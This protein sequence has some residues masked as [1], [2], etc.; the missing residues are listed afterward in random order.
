MA[1]QAPGII[2]VLRWLSVAIIIAAAFRLFMYTPYYAKSA[3]WILDHLVSFEVNPVAAQSQKSGQLSLEDT[4]EPGSPEWVARRAYLYEVNQSLNSADGQNFVLIQQRYQQLLKL[5]EQQKNLDGDE[6]Y[7][8]SAAIEKDSS[9]K[10]SSEIR[11]GSVDFLSQFAQEKD[12]PLFQQYREFLTKK[13]PHSSALNHPQSVNKALSKDPS[14]H[15]SLIDE[16]LVSDVT[17]INDQDASGLEKKPPYVTQ[18]LAHQPHAI[19][20]LGGGLTAGENKGEIVINSYTEERLQYAADLYKKFPLPI[21]LSGVESPYMQKWL[22]Q[23]GIEA[24]F[25]ENRSMNTC[26]N[27]RF[28]SLLLQKQGGAPT[29]FLVTDAYHMPR[30][31]R[32]FAIS[33]ISTIPVIAPL[34]SPLTAWKPDPQNLIHSRRATYEILA[35]LRD[36]WFGESNCREVP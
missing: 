2:I 36:L 11:T 9:T 31:R 28:S 12:E 33:G 8:F 14:K 10:P 24:Q 29:V 20:I 21:L 7:L 22:K 5:I 27:I 15:K 1:E 26:E 30:S 25:Q 18:T 32:L 23:R 16:S 13:E 6:D 35:T 19:V 3:L 4:L 17:G 34:P